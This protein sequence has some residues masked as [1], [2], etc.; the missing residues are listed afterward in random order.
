MF[1]ESGANKSQ[2]ELLKERGLTEGVL[3]DLSSDKS[4]GIIGD[5][6]DLKRRSDVFG[7]N[8]KPVEPPVS[9]LKSI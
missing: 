3:R 7:A 4:T 5:E 6:K 1:Q 8:K 9:F 2:F